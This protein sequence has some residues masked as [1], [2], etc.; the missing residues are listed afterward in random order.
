MAQTAEDRPGVPVP[1][2]TQDRLVIRAEEAARL[3]VDRPHRLHQSTR[4]D[5]PEGVQVHPRD[6]RQ[7]QP[8]HVVL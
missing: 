8:L 2:Q 5:E 7:L 4:H 6:H 1:E 3:A